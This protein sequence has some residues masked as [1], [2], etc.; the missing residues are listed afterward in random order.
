MNYDGEVVFKPVGAVRDI[1]VN[2]SLQY[3]I[4]LNQPSERRQLATKD[5]PIS[6]AEK[7]E[8]QSANRHMNGRQRFRGSCPAEDGCP[9]AA[10]KKLLGGQCD[11]CARRPCPCD[12]VA[13]GKH[14]PVG[15]HIAAFSS[16]RHPAVRR[17]AGT[18]RAA[19][20]AMSTRAG[21]IPA[22]GADSVEEV[23]EVLS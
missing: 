14:R 5:A 6:L 3:A 23:P 4:G 20:A 13:V 9:P 11:K 8:R 19:S 17:T 12:M 2:E 22:K 18:R 15:A 16:C 1:P 21:R 7:L 10:A